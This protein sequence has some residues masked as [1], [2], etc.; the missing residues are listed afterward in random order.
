[1]KG[2]KSPE[3][4][5]YQMTGATTVKSM[6]LLSPA[7]VATVTVAAPDGR[8]G[9]TMTVSVSS[10]HGLPLRAA[11]T[12]LNLTVPF[13]VPKPVPAI[14][15]SELGGPE[16][17]ERLLITGPVAFAAA[18][19]TV[20]GQ[21]L[22]A[23]AAVVTVTV[24][25]P[26]FRVLGIVVTILVTVALF[27]VAAVSPNLTVFAAGAGSKPV[28]V[29][30]IGAPAM[31]EDTVGFVIAGLFPFCLAAVEARGVAGGLALG[32]AAEPDFAF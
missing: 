12:P 28:P 19:A 15:T 4:T 26:D 32:C 24:V 25:F 2:L 10:V 5:P 1:M 7:D 20:N 27:T 3:T 8:F 23:P 14:F 29:M 13:L 11:S 17:G 31:P 21:A 30:T 16:G 6:L 18:T 9:G 22:P